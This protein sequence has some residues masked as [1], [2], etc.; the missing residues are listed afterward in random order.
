MHYE[1]LWCIRSIA[2]LSDGA[3]VAFILYNNQMRT[4]FS[5][6]SKVTWIVH[7]IIL[8]ALFVSRSWAACLAHTRRHQPRLRPAE[9]ISGAAQHGKFISVSTPQPRIVMILTVNKIYN[10]TRGRWG[11]IFVDI[12]VASEQEGPE[13][14]SWVRLPAFLCG[15]SPGASLFFSLSK[16]IYIYVIQGC[17]IASKC[18]SVRV[19]IVCLCV[20]CD[21]LAT[22]LGC[23]C[24]P[25]R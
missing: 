13:F 4:L 25:Q 17:W 11:E 19:Y 14:N 18:E 7:Q 22:C 5:H 10:I 16:H 8:V 3:P 12:T 23:V 1:K 20:P 21:G 15:V 24:V 6:L 9:S 2:R